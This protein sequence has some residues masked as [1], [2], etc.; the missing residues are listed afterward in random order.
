MLLNH[1]CL[2]WIP[3]WIF[4]LLPSCWCRKLLK[5][6]FWKRAAYFE[7]E[8][9]RSVPSESEFCKV[10]HVW[11]IRAHSIS[12]RAPAFIAAKTNIRSFMAFLEPCKPIYWWFIE[13]TIL[14]LMVRVM[15]MRQSQYLLKKCFALPWTMRWIWC[16]TFWRLFDENKGLFEHISWNI[17]CL[18]N[19][20]TTV[21]LC[22]IPLCSRCDWHWL[23]NSYS[24]ATTVITDHGASEPIRCV[25][26]PVPA[27]WPAP[28]THH[29][30][31][32]TDSFNKMRCYVDFR[33]S[34]YVGWIFLQVP[35]SAYVSLSSD[36]CR[37][38]DIPSHGVLISTR[39]RHW[40]TMITIHPFFIA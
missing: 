17:H 31:Q 25:T 32:Q 34:W 5:H 24:R 26:R 9:E 14:V 11:A 33:G 22:H 23:T 3:L 6:L 15:E 30:N 7:A 13:E 35:V 39:E 38:G 27:Q 29:T 10:R 36:F 2:G 12:A 16:W 28:L 19:C 18:F 1:L 20:S 8:T 40:L 37:L 21:Q 4:D